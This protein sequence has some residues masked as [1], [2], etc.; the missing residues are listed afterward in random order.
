LKNEGILHAFLA[1]LTAGLAEK[2]RRPQSGIKS[3]V[4]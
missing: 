2:I 1:F 4:P 3:E